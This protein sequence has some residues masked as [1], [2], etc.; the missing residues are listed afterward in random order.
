MFE[1][2]DQLTEIPAMTAQQV[3]DRVAT[4]LFTQGRRATLGLAGGC[5]YRTP[6]G[7]KCAVGCMI[8]D[9]LYLPEMD[10]NAKDSN[11]GLSAEEL[12]EEFSEMEPL[13]PH[14]DLLMDLQSVHDGYPSWDNAESVLRKRIKKVAGEF[15]LDAS[16]LAGLKFTQIETA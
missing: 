4:H 6:D 5:R 13:R 3:F 15:G 7:L 2:Y 11:L 14:M 16:I 8:P 9:A 12:I 10:K 1:N